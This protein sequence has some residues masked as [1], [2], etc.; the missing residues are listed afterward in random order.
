LPVNPSEITQAILS[1]AMATESKPVD[2]TQKPSPF[3]MKRIIICCDGTWQASNHGI[4]TVPSN[5]A[6]LSRAIASCKENGSGEFIHQIVYYHAGV[7][8]ATSSVH[9]AGFIQDKIADV[10]KK[11][12]GGVGAGLDE[13]V[14][15]AYNFIV[16]SSA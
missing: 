10:V 13:N 5:I 3:P 16:W 12:E 4:T 9:N 6:K 11:W 15:E 14:C 7:G 8:T 2:S 1:F